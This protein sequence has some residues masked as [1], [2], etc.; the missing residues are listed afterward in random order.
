[1]ASKFRLFSVLTNERYKSFNF[2]WAYYLELYS[3]SQKSAIFNHSAI[4]FSCPV[5]SFRPVPYMTPREKFYVPG[6]TP[7]YQQ[8]ALVSIISCFFSLYWNFTF[9]FLFKANYCRRP[10]YE[11]ILADDWRWVSWRHGG[12]VISFI[13]K[14]YGEKYVTAIVKNS[15]EFWNQWTLMALAPFLLTYRP[16]WNTTVLFFF[17]IKC[18]RNVW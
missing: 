14:Q 11:R 13:I 3:F 18:D 8:N 12:Q 7:Y 16:N 17:H 6:W 15:S 5:L 9:Y 1:M 4:W 10:W 2:E